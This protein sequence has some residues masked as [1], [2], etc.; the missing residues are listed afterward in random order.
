MDKIRAARFAAELLGKN[1]GGWIIGPLIDNGASAAVFKADFDGRTGAL[2]V[3]DPEV[4][5]RDARGSLRSMKL[6]ICC[7]LMA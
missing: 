5:E 4:V 2:K 7:E 6:L 1:I 3:F